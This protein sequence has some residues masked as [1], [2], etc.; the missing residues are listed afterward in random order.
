MEPVM[1]WDAELQKHVPR[2]APK[3]HSAYM[4]LYERMPPPTMETVISHAPQRDRIM[5]DS[6]DFIWIMI[7]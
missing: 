2:L 7:K 1:Q 3:P 5:F 6:N 4:L